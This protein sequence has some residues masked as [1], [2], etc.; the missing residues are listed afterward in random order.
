MD[1]ILKLFNLSCPKEKRKYFFI[2]LSVE[3]DLSP[4]QFEA[5]ILKNMRIA[6]A[7]FGNVDSIFE[8][9]IV[10]KRSSAI[11]MFYLSSHKRTCLK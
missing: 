5:A 11:D 9:I 6:V 7:T 10:L 1:N 2:L 4:L 8:S 3:K